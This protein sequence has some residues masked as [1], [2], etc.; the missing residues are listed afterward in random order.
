MDNRKKYI[1]YVNGPQKL[2]RI[3]AAE[4][5]Y[6]KWFRDNMPDRQDTGDTAPSGYFFFKLKEGAHIY[7]CSSHELITEIMAGV[8]PW[9]R[10]NANIRRVHDEYDGME[11]EVPVPAG[12]GRPPGTWGP[13]TIVV[14]NV[15]VI[16]P[17][18]LE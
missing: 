3:C 18:T 4:T 12:P 10:D 6:D 2:K 1:C 17:E 9:I 8:F 5:E 16:D 15:G 13:N 14:W 11:L 7:K